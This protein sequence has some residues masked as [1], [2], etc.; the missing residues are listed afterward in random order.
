MFDSTKFDNL[1]FKYKNTR[2]PQI[3]TNTP[4]QDQPVKPKRRLSQIE[5]KLATVN[6]ESDLKSYAQLDTPSKRQVTLNDK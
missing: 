3:V 1:L 4:D 6:C 5:R 2:L